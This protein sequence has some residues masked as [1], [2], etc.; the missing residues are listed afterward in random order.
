[1]AGDHD[2]PSII[3]RGGTDA[4]PALHS[5]D[6]GAGSIIDR[7]RKAGR[8]QSTIRTTERVRLQRGPGGRVLR[9]ETVP[10]RTPAPIEELMDALERH[11]IVHPVARM[12][13][14]ATLKN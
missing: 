8:L 3:G 13:P 12:R 4:L 1:V 2:V 7:W 5:Y 9:H 14:I 6:H 10:V 11:D